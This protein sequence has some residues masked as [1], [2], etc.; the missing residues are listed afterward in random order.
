ME[1]LDHSGKSLLLVMLD[2][3]TVWFGQCNWTAKAMVADGTKSEILRV[4]KYM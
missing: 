4:D 1:K 3:E 2:T